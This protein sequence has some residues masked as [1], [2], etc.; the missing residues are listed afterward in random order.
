[1]SPRIAIA[2]L[3]WNGREF[4]AKFL[5]Y[6][7]QYSSQ[8]AEVYVIDNASSD[9]SVAFLRENFSGIKIIENSENYGFAGGYNRGL[10]FIEA[11]YYIILNS[12]IEVT[13]A[14]IYPMIDFLEAHPEVAACQPKIRSFNERNKF[15]YAGASGGYIDFWG[16]PF[17]RGRLFQ[18]IET[19]H[20]QY[21]DITEIFWASGACL[22]IRRECFWEVGGFDEDF[23]AHMEEIDLCWRLKNKGYKIM[24]VP[25][26]TVFHVGGGTLPKK[27][28]RKTYFNMRNNA[29]MLIKNLP[30]QWLP[31]VLFA[32]L[33][34]DFAAALK[35]L[36]DGG[37]R[38]FWAVFKAYSSLI[39]SFRYTLE[40]RGKQPLRQVSRVYGGSIVWCY[41]IR[42]K[43]YF[44]TLKPEKFSK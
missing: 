44:S 33:F 20:G 11:E 17:C 14:W 42:R 36:V 29:L 22:M 41:Y 12:D 16:Y 18:A 26:A 24:V 8:V 31:I 4:L 3:N 9:G 15:E 6:V 1:M 30:K 2:I 34:L 5:P 10:K 43:R 32:R 21:D 13:P 28:W 35:F 37:F 38:N 27:S 23:F 7:L 40:K 19:D 25:Q 39:K